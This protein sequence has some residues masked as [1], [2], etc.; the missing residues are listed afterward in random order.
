MRAWGFLVRY[1]LI[2][3][4]ESRAAFGFQFSPAIASN[5]RRARLSNN[6]MMPL[7]CM[8]IPVTY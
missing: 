6:L 3:V 7:R 5:Q 2:A 4:L 1:N 8:I